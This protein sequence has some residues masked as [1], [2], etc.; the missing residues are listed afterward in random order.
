LKKMVSPACRSIHKIA[1]IAKRATS[2]IQ[3][4]ILFGSRQKA[5]ADQ[6]TLRC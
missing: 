1:C 5:A 4:K 6:I 2:K 3:V